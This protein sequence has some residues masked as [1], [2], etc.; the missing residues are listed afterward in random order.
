MGCS[1]S[2][3]PLNSGQVP[4]SFSVNLPRR[5]TNKGPFK[6]SSAL[7][8]L[9]NIQTAV[10]L[11]KVQNKDA[12]A[13]NNVQELE[14][15]ELDD[16][17]CDVK[18]M[19]RESNRSSLPSSP[20]SFADMNTSTE[21]MCVNKMEI[22]KKK[23]KRNDCSSTS[24]EHKVILHS[25]ERSL[26]EIAM[27]GT[28]AGGGGSSSHHHMSEFVAEL[29]HDKGGGNVKYTNRPNRQSLINRFSLN[30]ANSPMNSAVEIEKYYKEMG[31]SININTED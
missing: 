4:S 29:Q 15:E 21:I 12:A 9:V 16:N 28:S 11:P 27:V 25:K 30:S 5:V 3:V 17:E 13:Q 1:V 2:S 23:K 20:S 6:G 24:I 19:R 10:L 22:E 7:A 18:P 31:S 14:I 26:S 8:Q